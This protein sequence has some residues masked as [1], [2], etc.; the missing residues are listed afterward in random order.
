MSRDLISIDDAIRI[1]QRHHAVLDRRGKIEHES[2]R[3]RAGPEAY[4]FDGDWRCSV[5]ESGGEQ[6]GR[7]QPKASSR[8]VTADRCMRGR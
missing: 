4:V 5:R 2:R 7:Q 6:T 3:I 1:L 8:T